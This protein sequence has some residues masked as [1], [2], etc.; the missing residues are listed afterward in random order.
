MTYEND[1]PRLTTS[2]DPSDPFFC[3]LEAARLE[4]PTAEQLGELAGRVASMTGSGGFGLGRFSVA[5]TRLRAKSVQAGLFALAAAVGVGATMKYEGVFPFFKPASAP[6]APSP[7]KVPAPP[8]R[9]EVKAFAAPPPSALPE[10]AT[11]P[12]PAE[13][14]GHLRSAPSG[15]RAHEAPR[16]AA[17]SHQDF[18]ASDMDGIRNPEAESELLGRAHRELSSDP[19]QAFALTERHRVEYPSGALGQESDL[20]AIEALVAL[21]RGPEAQ[22]L[23]RRFRAHYPNSA[24]LRRLD[25]LFGESVPRGQ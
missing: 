9:L 18:P 3:A 22:A 5:R 23:A 25:R 8:P 17:P 12:E 21:G 19:A 15:V 4:L 11:A 20:I 16:P 2:G 14:A 13:P 10:P 6:T 7:A 1:P 24:H